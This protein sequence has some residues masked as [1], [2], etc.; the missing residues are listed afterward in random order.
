MQR[1][2]GV[3]SRLCLGVAREGK[4]LSAHAWLELGQELIIVGEAQAPYFKRLVE[5]GGERA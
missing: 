5:F 4:G 2:R 1:R 3:A